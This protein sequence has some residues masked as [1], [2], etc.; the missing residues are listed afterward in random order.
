MGICVQFCLYKEGVVV[1]ECDGF[2]VEFVW[3][4]WGD[5]FIVCVICGG[6]FCQVML[7]GSFLGQ[8][9]DVLVCVV[10]WGIR[11]VVV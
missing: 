7:V 9:L 2:Q 1:F 11:E 5:Y 10:W 4:S 6:V 3:F 8:F